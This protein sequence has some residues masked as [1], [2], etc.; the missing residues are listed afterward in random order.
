MISVQWV[1]IHLESVPCTIIIAIS[2]SHFLMINNDP[3]SYQWHQHDDL[4]SA[5]LPWVRR[6]RSH[7]IFLFTICQYTWT[8]FFNV[9]PKYWFVEHMEIRGQYMISHDC[10]WTIC[11]VWCSFYGIYISQ[12]FREQ[13]HKHKTLAYNAFVLRTF[14]TS[15]FFILLPTFFP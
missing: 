13:W 8:F 4:D 14:N 3:T 10:V 6:Q 7:R 12:C 1:I 9:D 15:I 2:I 11:F 5:C